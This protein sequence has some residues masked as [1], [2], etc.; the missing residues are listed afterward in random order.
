MLMVPCIVKPELD[1]PPPLPGAPL[2]PCGPVSAL[3]PSTPCHP[4]LLWDPE[5]W[6]LPLTLASR[7]DLTTPSNLEDPYHPL[8][9][10]NRCCPSAPE[11][12]ANPCRPWV[13]A[14]R[15]H[16]CHPSDLASRC[17]LWA[18]AAPAVPCH[19]CRLLVLETRYPHRSNACQR[20]PLSRLGVQSWWRKIYDPIPVHVNV[21]FDGFQARGISKK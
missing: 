21:L 16:L 10:A 19:P 2:G 6:C 18:L 14:V 3:D 9:L 1:N 13:L 8:D 20:S 11:D 12:L 17:H 5:D 4:C 15:C 7:L